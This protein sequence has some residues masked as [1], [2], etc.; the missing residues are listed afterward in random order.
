MG[1]CCINCNMKKKF[2][3]LSLIFRLPCSSIL[4][5]PFHSSRLRTK[6]RIRPYLQL[7]SHISVS[8]RNDARGI[9][10]KRCFYFPVALREAMKGKAQ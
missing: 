5:L 10:V 1:H 2:K 8:G 9:A 3:C 6:I 7:S 4:P